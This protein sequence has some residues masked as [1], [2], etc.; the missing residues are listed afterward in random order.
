MYGSSGALLSCDGNLQRTV[1]AMI[2]DDV[3]VRLV[4]TVSRREGGGGGDGGGGGGGG[5]DVEEDGEG[6]E[7]LDREVTLH[8]GSSYRSRQGGRDECCPY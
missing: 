5:G 3:Y 8:L 4:F 7:F 1:S 6:E 2:N